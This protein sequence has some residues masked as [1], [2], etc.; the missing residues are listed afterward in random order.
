MWWGILFDRIRG[1]AR[2]RARLNNG[3]AEDMGAAGDDGRRRAL[4][5]FQSHVSFIRPDDRM[6]D[7]LTFLSTNC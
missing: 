6:G 2:P 1:R 3:V 7:C 4:I 5:N